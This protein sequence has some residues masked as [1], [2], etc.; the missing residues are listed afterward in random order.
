MVAAIAV[1]A[2][3]VGH[4]PDPV[5]LV[6]GTNGGSGYT[7]PFRIVPDLSKRPEHLFQS[8]RSKGANIF[9]DCVTRTD[10]VDETVVLEPKPATAAR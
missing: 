7:V 1:Q 5:P 4:D 3:G 6:R 8:S 10:F 9:D 2:L